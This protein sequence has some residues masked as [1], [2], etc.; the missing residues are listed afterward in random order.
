MSRLLVVDDNA[1]MLSTLRLILLDAGFRVDTAASGEAAL[2]MVRTESYD[3]VVLDVRLPDIDGLEVCRIIRRESTVP[4]LMLTGLDGCDEKVNGLEAGADDY[5]TK[6]FDSRELV[7]RV[8]VLLRRLKL[9]G[10][11]ISPI[12]PDHLQVGGLE[13]DLIHRKVIRDGELIHLRPKEFDL[14]VFL[15]SHPGRTFTQS[16]LLE[17]VWRYDNPADTRTV[18]VHVRWL[19]EKLEADPSCPKLIE[20]VRGQG[21][22]LAAESIPPP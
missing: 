17:R 13:I 8:R 20:T 4:I 1:S 5:L 22:R 14:L 2:A 9:D 21:Y 11:Q 16:E 6:P 15:A 7:A 19:R 3:V 10:K 18:Q 12:I